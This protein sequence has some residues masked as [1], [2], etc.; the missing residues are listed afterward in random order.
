[1][2]ERSVDSP[3]L[4]RHDLD[5]S[6]FTSDRLDELCREAARRG[7]LKVQFADPGRQRYGNDPVYTYPRYPVLQDVL[8]RPIQYRIMGVASWG[9]AAYADALEHVFDVGGPDP[10]HGRVDV[11][12][13]VRV[14]SPHAVVALHGDPDLK[15]VCDVSGETI[16]YCRAPQ[17]M[18]PAEHEDL[19]RGGFFLPWRDTPEEALHIPPGHGCFVPSRWAHWLDHP[20]DEPVVS[21]ELGFWTVESVRRRKVEDVNWLLRRLRL[22]PA[23]P[24]EG[25]DLRKSQV[26]DL[27]SLVTRRGTQYR[28]VH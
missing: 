21:F 9:G 24:G 19:L 12:S 11:S 2:V 3:R 18:T 25:D 14:F 16:W 5:P 28:G 7:T 8:D 27:I 22:D 17:H 23:P 26:F 15:L 4:F 6:L 20:S 1:M 10:A 13:V